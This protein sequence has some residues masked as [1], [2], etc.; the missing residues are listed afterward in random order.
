[1]LASTAVLWH[2]RGLSS[3]LWWFGRHLSAFAPSAASKVPTVNPLGTE[4]P[5]RAL[6]EVRESKS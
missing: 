3:Y 2:V 1:M 6:S 4:R 5:R